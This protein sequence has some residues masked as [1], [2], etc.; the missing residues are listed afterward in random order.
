MA[1]T[2][3]TS[4]DHEE[5]QVFGTFTEAQLRNRLELEKGVFIVE[6]VTKMQKSIK[7]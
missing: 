4:L 6:S 1:I 2:E 3:I 5:V 7:I